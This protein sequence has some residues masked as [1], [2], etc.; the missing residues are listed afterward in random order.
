M[1]SAIYL[2]DKTMQT[3]NF[4]VN[5][6]FHAMNL[7]RKIMESDNNIDYIVIN[8]N[9]GNV[10]TFYDDN[11][12]VAIVLSVNGNQKVFSAEKTGRWDYQKQN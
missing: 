3:R 10:S 2:K 11:V 4:R 9:F 1:K 8:A 12:Y 5:D 7:S 6:I